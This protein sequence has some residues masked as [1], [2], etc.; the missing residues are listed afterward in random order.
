[1]TAPYT[2]HL[3][4]PRGGPPGQD[5]E[6]GTGEDD[7]TGVNLKPPEYISSADGVPIANGA[8]TNIIELEVDVPAMTAVIVYGYAAFENSSDT[9]VAQLTGSLY[10]DD[11]PIE[12]LGDFGLTLDTLEPDHGTVSIFA[13]HQPGEGTFTYALKTDASTVVAAD[14]VQA[15]RSRL[16]VVF[17]AI[18][19]A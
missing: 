12:S 5:G 19:P 14:M 4:S 18:P 6:D 2:K 3:V 1:M 9:T 8:E 17:T 16:M 15:F 13:P 10:V 11:D 7:A